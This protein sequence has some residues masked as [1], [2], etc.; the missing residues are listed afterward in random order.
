[1]HR[2]L[3][4]LGYALLT[5][6]GAI[7]AA[8]ADAIYDFSGEVTGAANYQTLAKLDVTD[9]AVASGAINFTIQGDGNCNN[10][11]G[12]TITGD[13]SGFIS[14]GL[15]PGFSSNYATGA[16]RV[17]LAFDTA[18]NLTGES[19]FE[20]GSLYDLMISG[21][22]DFSGTIAQDET[23]CEDALSQNANC[24][25]SG[26][27]YREDVPEAPTIFLFLAALTVVISTYV[28]FKPRGDAPEEV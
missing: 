12:C 21:A 23:L 9:A 8:Q 13:P 20:E 5:F 18:G 2:S 3:I 24:F 1:M 25:I 28:R 16:L 10:L 14:F 17:S 7:T 22:P 4:Y 26:Q 15:A 19:F 6:L 27:I 11:I